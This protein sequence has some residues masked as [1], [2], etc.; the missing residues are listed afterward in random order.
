[1]RDAS[2]AQ[3]DAALAGAARIRANAEELFGATLAEIRRQEFEASR[4]HDLPLAASTAELGARSTA[5][6]ASAVVDPAKRGEPS[7]N[8]SEAWLNELA[9]ALAA[10][11]KV[12]EA[13]ATRLALALEETVKNEDAAAAKRDTALARATLLEAEATDRFEGARAAVAAN[14]TSKADRLLADAL[15]RVETAAER[16]QAALADVALQHEQAAAQRRRALAEAPRALPQATG[17]RQAA[18]GQAAT[19]LESTVRRVESHLTTAAREEA[20]AASQAGAARRS[21]AE[22]RDFAQAAAIA[23]TA[24]SRTAALSAA[25]QHR[26]AFLQTIAPHREATLRAA[27]S[28][29][30][31][32]LAAAGVEDAPGGLLS[33]RLADGRPFTIRV[34]QESEAGLHVNIDGLECVIPT[35]DVVWWDRETI[36]TAQE[37]VGKAMSAVAVGVFPS[38]VIRLSE[39]AAVEPWRRSLWQHY[40]DQDVFWVDVLESNDQGVTIGYEDWVLDVS[41]I[42]RVSEWSHP[43]KPRNGGEHP[44][45][46]SIR[47][48]VTAYDRDRGQ[49]I[50]S[51]RAALVTLV[52]SGRAVGESFRGTVSGIRQTR[53]YVRIAGI[54]GYI[55]DEEMDWRQI[56]A[57]DLEDLAIEVGQELPVVMLPPWRSEIRLSARRAAW[58]MVRTR[59][60]AGQVVPGVAIAVGGG[61]VLLRLPDG[62]LGRAARHRVVEHIEGKR[63]AQY[64]SYV[65]SRGDIVPVKIISVN[66]QQV[67]IDVSYREGRA[68]ASGGARGSSTTTGG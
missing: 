52:D 61:E 60:S 62:V 25:A 59:F 26:E 29:Y 12:E 34:S 67:R 31:A 68:E 20:G 21:A 18:L 19:R 4:S 15:R 55:D 58:P 38:G 49:L 9:D 44:P 2:V 17:Q 39:R 10:A 23:A 47:V 66:H 14:Q 8:S 48:Q 6:L 27:A 28:R 45:P 3:Q 63:D 54:Y 65:I 7:A 42:M 16:R 1:M 37:L 46:V 40:R 11:A 22:L 64:P 36:A 24:E 32:L 13:A 43:D 50:L 57:I 51:E 30:Q 53:V 41:H 5:Y 33:Q 35:G 56:G